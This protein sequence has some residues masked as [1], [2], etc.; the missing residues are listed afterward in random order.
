SCAAASRCGENDFRASPGTSTWCPYD[1]ARASSRTATTPDTP[2]ERLPGRT[3]TA[4][5]HSRLPE[6]PP[7]MQ[8][9]DTTEEGE[10]RHCGTTPC[11]HPLFVQSCNNSCCSEQKLQFLATI[12]AARSRSGDSVNVPC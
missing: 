6:M 7:D 4:R 8:R 1:R 3:G 12:A 11:K 5:K 10:V 2:A 9:Q